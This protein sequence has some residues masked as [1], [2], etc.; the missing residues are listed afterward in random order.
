MESISLEVGE[1]QQT[2]R[3][4][5]CDRES[6]T[7]HGFIY[8]AGTAFAV[9]YAAWSRHHREHGVMLAIGMGAWGAGSSSADRTCIGMVARE[10]QY[11]ILFTIVGPA[12]S[13]WPET[14][15]FGTML[16][17]EEALASPMLS[18]AFAIAEHV[19]ANHPAIAAFLRTTVACAD[20]L[21][22]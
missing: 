14:E 20:A 7:G 19:V 16:T 10:G 18:E 15:L 22:N 4:A 9:Y 17:R 13:P 6:S 5:C 11:D 2:S 1:D 21:T 3:C 12:Q 8:R